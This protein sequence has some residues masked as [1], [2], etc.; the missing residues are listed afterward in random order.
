M[1]N[2]YRR[3]P[4]FPRK[5]PL[6][7]RRILVLLLAGCLLVALAYAGLR[8]MQSNPQ[9]TVADNT[10][11]PEKPK[12][13]P[14]APVAGSGSAGN[15]AKSSPPVPDTPG[16][17]AVESFNLYGAASVPGVQVLEEDLK[18]RAT[19]PPP[20]PRLSPDPVRPPAPAPMPPA[21]MSKEVLFASAQSY[22]P[23]ENT[24]K[25]QPAYD[26]PRPIYTDAVERHQNPWGQP[27]V[28][29]PLEEIAAILTQR[30]SGRAIA[31]QGRNITGVYTRLDT[32]AFAARGIS[33]T[34]VALTLDACDGQ[35]MDAEAAALLAFL[36]Q[37]RIPATIFVA[38][39]W[40]RANNKAF[41]ELAK[42]PLVEIAAHG[43]SHL[44]CTV[45][46]LSGQKTVGS[47]AELVSEVEGNVRDIWRTASRR[48]RWFRC[49]TEVYDTVAIAIMGDLAMRVAGS[50]VPLDT[51]TSTDE[52]KR[53]LQQAKNNDIISLRLADAGIWMEP[54]KQV[55]PELARKGMT[56]VRLSDSLA[57]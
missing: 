20:A 11:A 22:R 25:A 27:F 37:N 16:K 28:G 47:I 57:P 29:Y 34:V 14:V 40:L 56:F 31:E 23:T 46:S 42:E 43:R 24:E 2:V 8:C 35:K 50:S 33:G 53:L 26:R 51:E 17:E 12:A 44:G 6:P 48:P 3:Q 30:H 41:M 13:A 7:T 36:R 19:P 39:D 5:N 52:A 49:G 21:P 18:N 9:P 32:A 1:R 4:R 54:A 15:T 38:S 10:A 55:L 45:T